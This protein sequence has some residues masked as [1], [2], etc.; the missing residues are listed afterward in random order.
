M[1]QI[2]VTPN[3]LRCHRKPCNYVICSVLRKAVLDITG[4]KA[5]KIGH[6]N[7]APL[8][9]FGGIDFKAM[10]EDIDADFPELKIGKGYD[11]C[12]VVNDYADGEMRKVVTFMD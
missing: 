12:W 3:C 4:Q 8:P 2:S 1:A 7:E 11:A 10:G 9:C 5:V 6:E